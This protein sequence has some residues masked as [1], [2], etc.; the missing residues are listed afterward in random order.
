M[1]SLLTPEERDFILKLVPIKFHDGSSVNIS[2]A[3]DTKTRKFIYDE[4]RKRMH[5]HR[6]ELCIGIKT[7]CELWEEL[8][9]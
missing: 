4:L 9:R 3:Q 2:K 7:W 1:D 5:G 8:N 6:G